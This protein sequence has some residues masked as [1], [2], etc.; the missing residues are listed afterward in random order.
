MLVAF[1]LTSCVHDDDFSVPQE[2]GTEENKAL[3]ALLASGATEVSIG[4]LKL[5][6]ANN[7]KRPVVIDT[8]IYLKGYVSSSDR[9]GNFFK[10]LFVQDAAENPTA[11]IKLIIN[12][13]KS[14][15][16]FNVGRE[17]YIK[18]NGLY[19]GEE[20]VGNGVI[21]IGGLTATDQYG[22]VVKRLTEKQRTQ[23]LFRSQNTSQLIPLTLDFSEVS[24][25]HIGLYVQ[26]NAVE[27]VDNLEGHR[28]F[29]PA[30]DF[31]TSRRMQSCSGTIGYTYF[32]L[33]TSSFAKFKDLMLPMGN[34]SINGVITKTFDGS[35]LVLA[36][37]GIEDVALT[38]TRCP[39][40]SIEDFDIVFKEAFDLAH[41]AT[42]LNFEGWTNFA[43]AGKVKWKEKMSN[44]NGYTEFN[45][46]G[47][48]NSSNIAWLIIP[49][50]DM[51]AQSH[52]YLNFK[53]AQYEVRSP[54]NTL[55]VMASTDYNG[56]DVLAATWFPLEATVPSMNTPRN[57][58]VD[59]G[60]IDL[61]SYTGTLH[62]AFK[63]KGN[64]KKTSLSGAY[65]IDDIIIFGN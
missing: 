30:Q 61:T 60:L 35:G 18:L 31:D 27:F 48:G 26:F 8:D 19:V 50:F 55:E 42:D 5:K 10:E 22:T 62:I 7:H 11:G 25:E 54:N 17:V 57:E 16:Q 32:E 21:T 24:T 33:E 28:Y 20:R 58:F 34:G 51:N 56:I 4:E 43:Q 1:V 52:A 12:Q 49:A 39:P 13:V 45:V 6:Y 41:E 38:E 63:V 64:G 37:N 46:I 14:H 47:S 40:L 65:L 2:L 53:A 59:S 3:E 23:H 36:L 15:N 9:E 29:D 44:G